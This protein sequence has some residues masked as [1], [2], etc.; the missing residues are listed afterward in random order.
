M[1][2]HNLKQGTPEWHAL[3]AKFFTASEAPVVMGVSS[4]KTRSQ[5]LKEKASGA[6]QDNSDKAALF[7][8][9]HD[10]EASARPH[11]E[12]DI[13]DE[14]FPV[15]CTDDEER[16]L[17]SLD[18]ATMLGDRIW[19]HKLWNEKKAEQV[20]NQE[21]PEQDYWQIVHQLIVSGA[22]TCIYMVSDGTP[23]KMESIEVKLF[24]D[25]AKKLLAAWDQ[26]ERDLADYEHKPEKVEAVASA[27]TSLPAVSV[28]VSGEIGIKSN[29]D[30][31]ST[32][33]REYV[34]QINLSPQSDQDFADLDA[35][36]KTLKKAEESLTA[37]EDNA[38]AQTDSIQAMRKT[39]H[40]CRE[41]CR[42]TRLQAEKVVKA[43]KE[44][45]RAEIRRNAEQAFQSHLTELEKRIEPV[46]MPAIVA[47]IAGAM[48]GKKTIKSLEDA[49]DDAVAKAK[50]EANAIADTIQANLK[51]LEQEAGD[52][53]HL[54]HD[55]E[56]IAAKDPDDFAA[57]VK[58][59][60][61]DHKEAEEKRLE[62]E[63]ERI[64]EEEQEKAE[65]KQETEA[66]QAAEEDA[67]GAQGAEAKSHGAMPDKK[68]SRPS[69][70]E[71]IDLVARHYG[72]P[73]FTAIQ[74]LQ[75]LQASAA[76]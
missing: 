3:R 7:Q 27:Q 68:A 29:L 73:K 39:V 19:E 15:V 17:A 60:I 58:A 74:W 20:R 71:L 51:T 44:N 59:R 55:L 40:D 18:G 1:K 54:F 67:Q 69:D 57:V 25:D 64:R 32:A 38:L 23:D 52:Y 62:V 30:A 66:N 65:A 43:E 45:R 70:N 16:L 75:E 33:L 9:G 10:A 48:K 8:R 37:S 63:R 76:A 26:F 13:G 53:R 50:L 21:V 42:Q 24:E 61:A 2:L 31:F 11:A 22:T 72:V 35:T 36:V 41:L 47:D 56:S 46:R 5:L 49:A 6:E 12:Q 4:Y 34:D 14:L 28:Q